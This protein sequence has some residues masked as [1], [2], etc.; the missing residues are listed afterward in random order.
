MAVRAPEHRRIGP[1][2]RRARARR[3][4]ELVQAARGTRIKSRYLEALERDA[5]LEEFPA[6][7][8]ARAFLREYAQWL[9]LDP[10]PLVD[11]FIGEHPEQE[12]PLVLPIPVQKL[13]GRWARRILPAISIA[14]LLTLLVM[15]MRSGTPPRT[16]LPAASSPSAGESPAADATTAVPEPS[17]RGILL[18]ISIVEGPSWIRITS[19]GRVVTQTTMRP[20]SVDTFKANRR[21]D[22]WLGNAGAA[23]LTLNGRTV[24]IPASADVHRAS[25]IRQDG[26]IRIVPYVPT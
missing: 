18:A 5:P 12:A 22:V 11:S 7:V 10:E 17:T 4:I 3:G 14:L 9:G 26:R 2:L 19:D 21:L 1:K 6:P 23:R 8:Y 24:A 15:S 20:G 16:P 25:F 13:P